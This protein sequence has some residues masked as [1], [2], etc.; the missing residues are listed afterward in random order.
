M[1]RGHG[2]A[3]CAISVAVA[4]TTGADVV[5]AAF[6]ALQVSEQEEAFTRISD[7][8]L[9]RL[10]A[11]EDA[12]AYYL[13]S[14]RRVADIAGPDLSPDRYRSEWRALVAAGED[15]AEFNAVS[16]HFGSWR[17]AK[18]A[19]A[20]AEVTTA[21]KIEARFRS[22]LLGR[23]RTF[24]QEELE[25]AL[26]LCVADLG[27]VPLLAEYSEWRVKELA[28]A[29]TRGEAGRMPS[30]AVFRRRHGTWQ[31]A[32]LAC[33]YDAEEVYLRL[34][35]QPE[36]R[37]RV[38]KVDRYTEATLRDTL[39]RCARDLGRPPLVADFVDWRRR[40]L[41]RTRARD[42][43]CPSDSPYRRRFGSWERALL[44]FGFDAEEVNGRLVPGRERSTEAAR[45]PRSRSAP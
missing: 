26:R 16:R 1:A 20:L 21:A 24:K 28:L 43:M 23:Q 22:R 42:V 5:I 45:Q 27:R 18:E 19:V 4:L 7:L 17:E 44:Y 32:L 33:G 3:G 14:L 25:A 40:E 34:E 9:T 10:A 31:T 12:T 39:T 2:C 36:R 8:R 29:R 35:P 37:S 38:A 6:A 41:A 30:T 13:R 15:V 11:E